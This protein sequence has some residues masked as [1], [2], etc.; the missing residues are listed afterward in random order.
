MCRYVAFSGT[1]PRCGGVFTWD[2]LSQQL[3]CLEAKNNGIFGDC[4][5]GIQVEPHSFDQECDPCAEASMMELMAAA[6]TGGGVAHHA[7][8]KKRRVQ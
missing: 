4:R 7:T 3:S 8:S 6:G 1:C 2:D 5:K